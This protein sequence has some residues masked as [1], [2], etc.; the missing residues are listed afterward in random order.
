M[1]KVQFQEVI[2]K[3]SESQDIESALKEW[4][5]FG[6]HHFLLE[7]ETQCACGHTCKIFRW[8]VNSKNKHPIRVADTCF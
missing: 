6:P 2:L 7:S 3:F 1:S 5:P 4:Y 8:M